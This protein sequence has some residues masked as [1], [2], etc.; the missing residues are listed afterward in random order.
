MLTLLFVGFIVQKNAAAQTTSR[1][2]SLK[3]YTSCRFEDDLKVVQVD[4]L[5]KGVTFRTVTTSSG[6]KKVSLADGYR[7][8]VAYPKADFFA[9]IKAEK[10]NP[11][12]Y[13]KDKET[14]TEGL[15]WAI[16]NGKEM[17]SQEPLKV[18]YNGFEGYAMNRKSLVGNTLGIT[19]LF[20]DAEHHI[21]TIYFLNENPKKRKFQTIEEWRTLRDNFLNRYTSC[22]K[23]NSQP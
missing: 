21:I 9:N 7:V 13:A 14:V 10:S 18:S 2:D 23:V 19:V 3:P 12:D 20:S 8:M 5:P 11:D 15:K 16:A 17:E 22:V 6:E 4:R 1:D